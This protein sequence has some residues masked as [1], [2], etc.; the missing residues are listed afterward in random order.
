MALFYMPTGELVQNIGTHLSI[1]IFHPSKIWK[2]VNVIAI[3]KKNDPSDAAY[4]RPISLLS[5]VK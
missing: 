5:I 1:V 3:Y 4:Y 2:E